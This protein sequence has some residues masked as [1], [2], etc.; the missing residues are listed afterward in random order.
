[1]TE[2]I[3]RRIKKIIQGQGMLE[4]ISYSLTTLEKATSY[5]L[6]PKP[7]VKIAMP[8]NTSRSVMRQNLICGLLD[9]AAYNMARNQSNIGIYEQG[10]VYYKDDS[11]YIEHEHIAALYSGNIYADNWQHLDQNID[12]YYVKGQLTNIFIELGLD[13]HDIVYKAENIKGM[14]PT[15]TAAIYLKNKYLGMIGMLSHEELYSEKALRG[16]EI[17]VYE[18]DLDVLIPE[19]SKG[20][21]AKSAPKFPAINRDLSLLIDAHITNDA[22][23]SN[24][25]ANAGKYLTDIKVIDVYEGSQIEAGKKSIAYSLTFRNEKE[26]LTDE[27]VSLAIAEI[28]HNLESEL[29]A[30]VR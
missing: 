28:T 13:L 14:H 11:N 21:T 1:P 23:I 2:S 24:I 6:N 7:T 5:A 16:N 15:R 10:R 25:K 22:I 20:V 8:L 9:A 30:V 27:V 26:T 17:Y 4:A 18:L 3:I 12:F 19:I 29:G